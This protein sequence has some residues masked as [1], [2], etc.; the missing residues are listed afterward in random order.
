LLIR[1][2]VCALWLTMFAACNHGAIAPETS[3]GPRSTQ[4]TGRS[5][6]IGSRGSLAS[7][8]PTSEDASAALIALRMADFPG[9]GHDPGGMEVR[10]FIEHDELTSRPVIDRGTVIR[11]DKWYCSLGAH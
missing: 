7:A 9:V 11:I 6:A 5:S 1:N 3:T 10:R 8:D 2:A 4:R